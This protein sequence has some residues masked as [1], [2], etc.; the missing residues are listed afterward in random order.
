MLAVTEDHLHQI[1]HRIS[2]M[3]ILFLENKNYLIFK[4]HQQ[5]TLMTYTTW[6]SFNYHHSKAPLLHR[7]LSPLT[8][9]H[10]YR[11]A[12]TKDYLY[13]TNHRIS[14]MNINFMICTSNI[15]S[16]LTLKELLLTIIIL[17]HYSYIYILNQW[18]F[19]TLN[20][21]LL[22]KNTCIM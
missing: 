19:I 21:L 12:V 5:K 22:K 7:Y 17:R 18:K 6:T 2:K 16:R 10:Y 1:N 14:I 15:L 8:I 4:L 3:N 11:L 20:S 9:Y 13:H